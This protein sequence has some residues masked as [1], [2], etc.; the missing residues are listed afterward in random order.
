MLGN[1]QKRGFTTKHGCS[2]S[3][4]AQGQSSLTDREVPEPGEG[5]GESF[6]FLISPERGA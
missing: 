3:L 5:K 4:G 2:S 1:F 6:P